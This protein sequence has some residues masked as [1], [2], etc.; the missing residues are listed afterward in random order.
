MLDQALYIQDLLLK[1]SLLS[2]N[3]VLIPMV[4]GSYITLKE[5]NDR[6]HTEITTYQ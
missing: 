6:D 2:C 3:T 4:P 1:E 5:E